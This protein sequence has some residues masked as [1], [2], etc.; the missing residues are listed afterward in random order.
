MGDALV[1]MEEV[2]WGVVAREQ[3]CGGVVVI[4]M[5]G[6]EEGWSHG[7]VNVCWSRRD[8]PG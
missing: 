2:G 7:V 6:V 1:A 5:R 4:V 8:L 3:V